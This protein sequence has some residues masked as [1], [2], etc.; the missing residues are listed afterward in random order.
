[1]NK[2]DLFDRAIAAW[3][4]VCETEKRTAR[5]AS[6]ADSIV[7]VDSG[8]VVLVDAKGKLM[9][10]FRYDAVRNHLQQIRGCTD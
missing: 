9:V 2:S 4:E 7:D 8:I 10:V 3:L 5:P 1:M 6:Y